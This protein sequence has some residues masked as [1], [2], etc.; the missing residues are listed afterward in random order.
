ME[1][2]KKYLNNFKYTISKIA[3]IAKQRPAKQ[4]K[5]R[6]TGDKRLLMNSESELK[7]E[8]IEKCNELNAKWKY[9]YGSKGRDNSRRVK[10]WWRF[11]VCLY[12]WCY[13]S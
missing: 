8:E 1:S 7:D 11:N 4:H 2:Q 6:C 5:L 13:L 9:F 3:W 12:V 10:K